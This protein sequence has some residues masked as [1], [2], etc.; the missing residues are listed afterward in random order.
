MKSTLAVVVAL[1]VGLALGSWSVKSDLRVAKEEIKELKKSINT[2]TTRQTAL[3]TVTSALKLP[4]TPRSSTRPEP[5]HSDAPTQAVTVVTETGATNTTPH[6]ARS[7]SMEEG[8]RTAVEAWQTRSA[9]ARDSFLSNIQAQPV[10]QQ[11]FDQAVQKMNEQLAER[12]QQWA[13]Y[14]KQQKD[15]TPETGVRMMNNLS[16][17]VIAAYD[18]LDRT[19]AV[20]WREKAGEKFQLFDFINPEVAMPLAEVEGAIQRSG[21]R[22]HDRE[23]TE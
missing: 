13:E 7:R 2:R 1:L 6:G 19:Q 3:R 23:E 21:R 16:E 15:M 17:P 20:G 14:I 22:Y 5:I 11:M 18:E 8:L 4:E 10:Q 9:L 12:I